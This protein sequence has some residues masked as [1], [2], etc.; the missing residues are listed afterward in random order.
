II[1]NQTKDLNC[2]SVGKNSYEI[3]KADGMIQVLRDNK[4]PVKVV[5]EYDYSKEGKTAEYEKQILFGFF[6]RVK[7]SQMVKDVSMKIKSD[8]KGKL[9]A[10]QLSELSTKTLPLLFKSAQR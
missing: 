6:P 2:I 5:L 9:T 7:V 8:A 4:T 3:R 1:V 10:S